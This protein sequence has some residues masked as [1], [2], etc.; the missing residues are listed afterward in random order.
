MALIDELTKQENS[1]TE[2][3]NVPSEKDAKS[4]D[5]EE[6]SQQEDSIEEQVLVDYPLVRKFDRPFVRA[7]NLLVSMNIFFSETSY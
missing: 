7:L 1:G 2:K 5:K 3:N 6:D 4:D